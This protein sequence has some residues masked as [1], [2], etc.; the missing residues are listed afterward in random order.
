MVY[1]YPPK[2]YGFDAF[3]AATARL[4]T[5]IRSL[6]VNAPPALAVPPAAVALGAAAAAGD[7]IGPWATAAIACAATITS[8]TMLGTAKTKV[9]AVS[10]KPAAK[11]PSFFISMIRSSA[12]SS[13]PV[14]IATRFPLNWK[15]SQ[16]KRANIRRRADEPLRLET[17]LNRYVGI[18]A[19]HGY[20]GAHDL[21][22]LGVS[23][24]AGWPSKAAPAG[25]VRFPC[26]CAVCPKI[27]Q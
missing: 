5:S 25:A 13:T 21:R 20:S 8:P 23:S 11:L 27:V 14:S 26:S 19:A 10:M 12:A 16:N 24:L 22:L 18:S 4:L 7:N 3:L 1:S 9:L 17:R 15:W 2:R 6:S